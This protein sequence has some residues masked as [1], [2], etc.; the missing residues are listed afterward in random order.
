MGGP[1]S[2]WQG[3]V[4]SSSRAQ[5]I[6]YQNGASPGKIN[7][8]SVYL[9]ITTDIFFVYLFVFLLISA[10]APSSIDGLITLQNGILLFAIS[11]KI[12]S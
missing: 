12:I 7:N 3:R 8:P 4:T 9:L 1:K 2:E 11:C 10:S 6:G 5:L